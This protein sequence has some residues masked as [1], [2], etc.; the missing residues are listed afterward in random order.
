MENLACLCDAP[1]AGRRGNVVLHTTMVFVGYDAC[2]RYPLAL[3]ER[4]RNNAGQVWFGSDF[5][6]IP[7][8]LSHAVES[9]LAPPFSVEWKRGI[10]AENAAALFGANAPE[11]PWADA[12]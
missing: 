7:Y 3:P 1:A 12:H 5:P 8:P 10:L 9:L 4:L 2:G 11:T 6:V